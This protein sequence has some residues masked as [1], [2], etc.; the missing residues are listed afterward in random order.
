MFR[1]HSKST[2]GER[3]QKYQSLSEAVAVV[4]GKKHH[5][6]NSISV[7]YLLKKEKGKKKKKRTQDFQSPA[8]K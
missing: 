1:L 2:W 4:N 3:K 8:P 6:H 7:W 5:S